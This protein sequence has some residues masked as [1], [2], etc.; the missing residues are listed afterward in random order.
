MRKQKTAQNPG[1]DTGPTTTPRRSVGVKELSLIIGLTE[2]SIRLYLCVPRY[3]H[4]VPGG[5]FKRPGSHQWR[6]WLDEVLE[7]M[8]SG[9]KAADA[10]R[11]RGRPKGSTTRA[12]RKRREAERASLAGGA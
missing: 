12:M 6:W 11:P 2:Q 3:R 7:W 1:V 8:A 5:G 9:R 10:P 4:L